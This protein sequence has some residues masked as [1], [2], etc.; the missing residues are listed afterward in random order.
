MLA[1]AGTPVFA[2]SS[3]SSATLVVGDSTSGLWAA[4]NFNPYASGNLWGTGGPIYEPMFY[5][6]NVNGKTYDLLGTSY[7]WSKDERTLIVQLR[8]GVKWNDGKPF[9]SADVVYTFNFL[10]AHPATDG[11][12]VW[13][14]IKSVEAAG[15][16]E[17]KFNF[18]RVNPTFSVYLLQ[19]LIIPQHIF[20]D[21]KGDPT[22]WTDPDPVGTGPYTVKSFSPQAYY[23]QANPTYWGGKPAVS[24]VEL[25]AYNGNESADLAL[26]SGKFDWGGYFIPNIQ[27][28]YVN[29]DSKDNHYWFPPGS[30]VMLYPNQKDP[31]LRE[32]PVRKAIN[33]AINRD[34]LYKIAEYGYEPVASSTGLILPNQKQW[35]D[36]KLKNKLYTSYDPQAAIKILENAGYKKGSDGIFV[37]PSGQPLKFSLIV[38]AGWTD[39]DEQCMMIKQDL[40]NIGIQVDVHQE[41]YGDWW[42]QLTTGK[43]QLAMCWSSQGPNPFYFYDNLMWPR[44]PN[45]FENWVGSGSL[46]NL[47]RFMYTTNANVQKRSIYNLENYVADKLPAIPLVYG[48]TWYEYRTANFVGWPNATDPYV[49]PA[50]WGISTEIVLTHLKPAH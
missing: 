30:P 39:W 29:K 5:F 41:Q 14:Q 32:L 12:G 50:P 26:A 25:P 9:T 13:R 42:N 48:A 22:K 21:Y 44:N 28:I 1:P 19:T 34:P 38:V 15:D 36:P 27:K 6:S 24:E 7:T 23:L 37:S 10:K 35:I 4:R 17:V 47:S 11:M 8:K 49:D 43:Y 45:N 16:Y 33:L 46:S 40:Q 20:A 31:A 3:S 18:D 2:A